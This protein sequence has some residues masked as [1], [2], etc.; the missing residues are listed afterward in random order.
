[1][2]EMKTG[3][4]TRITENGE[5]TY[6]FNF[7]TNLSVDKK[8]KFVNSIVDLVVDEGRYNSIIKD[9]LFDFYVIDMMTDID[10][11]DLLESNNFLCDTEEFLYETNIV[12]IVKANA[13]PTLFDE[14]NKSVDLNIEYLTGIHINPLN[15]ALTS[16]V[17]TLEKKINE[18]DSDNMMKMANA[19]GNMNG[20]ITPESIVNA[21]MNSD[22]Y[23]KNLEEISESKKSSK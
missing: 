23:K 3:V 2:K 13:F 8:I 4:Y 16:L 6:Q 17:N 14:L 21:Y 22:I 1:M 18:I 10:T 5:E 7:Y 9:L 12:E 20:E 11:K 19:F 15:N